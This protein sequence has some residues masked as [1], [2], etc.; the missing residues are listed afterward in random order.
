MCVIMFHGS[1]KGRFAA[2]RRCGSVDPA[3]ASR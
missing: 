3:K 2:T 1:R